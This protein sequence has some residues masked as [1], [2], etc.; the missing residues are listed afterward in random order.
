M[1]QLQ[2]EYQACMGST[3]H[4]W[5]G[6]DGAQAHSL[7]LGWAGCGLP[8]DA[9]RCA[10][11]TT[12]GDGMSWRNTSS[13]GTSLEWCKM[14]VRPAPAFTTNP[15]ISLS[16]PPPPPPPPPPG[17]SRWPSRSPGVRL[18]PFFLPPFFFL[19][20]CG[21]VGILVVLSLFLSLFPP[22]LAGPSNRA[23]AAAA[24]AQ[25]QASVPVPIRVYVCSKACRVWVRCGVRERR[26]R[27]EREKP[28]INFWSRSFSCSVSGGWRLYIKASV[29]WCGRCL[30]ET[31]RSECD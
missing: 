2:G 6:C 24:A 21:M 4:A 11:F 26:E 7:L 22:S 9:M 3:K 8:N 18:P 16:S 23:A 31:R 29:Q 20:V 28:H 1:G 13:G 10:A 5:G 17:P 19:L 25:M 27:R 15:F 30:R 14:V 12:F